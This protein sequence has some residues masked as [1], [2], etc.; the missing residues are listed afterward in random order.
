[1][2]FGK[3]NA[4]AFAAIN[5][6]T[7]HAGL[8]IGAESNNVAFTVAMAHSY[9][10]TEI[11]NY[12]S[13]QIGYIYPFTE[14]HSFVIGLH[15]GMAY[16]SRK[17]IKDNDVESSPKEFKG[18]YTAEFGKDM[19]TGRLSITATYVGKVYYGI[20]IKCFL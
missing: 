10:K 17:V 19:H 2:L 11:P 8:S 16:T 14:E 13:M 1:M 7:Y 3:I 5:L 15:G 6:G 12:Y 20:S 9:W 18:I 4:Q